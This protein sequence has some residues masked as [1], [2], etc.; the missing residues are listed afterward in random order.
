M[1]F[2]LCK[3]AHERDRGGAVIEYLRLRLMLGSSF[4]DTFSFWGSSVSTFDG[5]GVVSGS[6]PLQGL[7]L[8]GATGATVRLRGFI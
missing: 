3:G 2:G 5:E 1:P 7:H 4:I 6:G 8:T